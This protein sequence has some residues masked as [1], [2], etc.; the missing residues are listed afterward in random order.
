MST[1]TV[2]NATSEPMTQEFDGVFSEYHS[3]I[4]RT[5]YGVTGS[6]EDA[7]DI[8]QT[9]M[10]RVF[11]REI[12]LDAAKNPKSYLY[13]TAVNLA[14]GV[15]RSRRRFVAVEAIGDVEGAVSVETPNRDEELHRKLYE[16]IAELQPKAAEILILRY[17]H[18]YNDAQIAKLLGTSRGSI[19]VNLYRSRARLKKLLHASMGD[20]S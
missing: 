6:A 14:L 3:L 19:A 18:N 1:L 12:R 5:A 7:E 13:R 15:V 2:S 16:A 9:V 10:M 17:V 11:R 8:V 20:H 4:Y